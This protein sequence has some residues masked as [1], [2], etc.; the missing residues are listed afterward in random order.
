MTQKIDTFLDRATTGLAS[1]PELRLDV[2][3]ELRSHIEDKTAEL[4]GEEHADEAVACLGEV[5]ELAEE[6]SAANQRRLGWRN[7]AR[8]VLRFGLV[9]VAVV[10]AFWFSGWRQIHAVRAYQ[11][12]YRSNILQLPVPEESRLPRY[13]RLLFYGDSSREGVF[14]Y[15]TLWEENPTNRVYYADYITHLVECGRVPV[16]PAEFCSL[17]EEKALERRATLAEY[18]EAQKVDPLNSRYPML[19]AMYQASAAAEL[20]VQ[21][22]SESK[23]RTWDLKISDRAALDQAMA[24]LV[25]AAKLPEY[26]RH[27]AQVMEERLAVFGRPRCLV[28]FFRWFGVASST[29]LPDLQRVRESARFSIAYA[30]LLVAEGHPEKAGPFLQ[31]PEILARKV[32]GDTS[33]LIDYLVS[34]ALFHI[35][36]ENVP[37][38]LRQIGHD[39]EA[40]AT[41][42]RLDAVLQPME[43]WNRRRHG[44]TPDLDK[45][46][47]ERAGV[48]ATMLL[49][50][51]GGLDVADLAPRLAASRRMELAFA[52]EIVTGL[53]GLLLVVAMIVSLAV[54][55]RWRIALGRQSAPLLLLPS[56]RDLCRFVLLGVVLPFAVFLAWTRWLP[57]SGQAYSFKYAGHRVT[58]EFVALL[59]TLLVLPSW[60][61]LRAFRRRCAELELPL[62]PRLHWAIRGLFPLAG[63]LLVAVFLVPPGASIV[64]ASAVVAAASG[65]VVALAVLGI[66]ALSLFVARQHGRTVGTLSRSL[67]PVFAVAILLLSAGAMPLLRLRE[68]QLLGADTILGVTGSPGFSQIENQLTTRLRQETLQAMAE[69]P[70]P[71]GGEK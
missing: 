29:L 8:H 68:R 58:A 21:E 20:D 31:L 55:F 48:F 64:R 24:D 53:V 32:T 3:A 1:D 62:P 54:S 22:P 4:G 46:L 44:P 39:K 30:R 56:G 37:D 52:A 6:V 9:P 35:A 19:A 45:L 18:A 13:E 50:A 36:R 11:K 71:A 14:R 17:K 34:Q 59:V 70:M 10:C 57:F 26:R 41:E 65:G 40:Q 47:D 51:L 15:R 7:L 43:Q 63:L 61:A 60:L 66:V 42:A 28:D 33:F 16:H 25:A 27:R 5:V 49:P 38:V 23:K 12:H 2:Q 67:I 69:N